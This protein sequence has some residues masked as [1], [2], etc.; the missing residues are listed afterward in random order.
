MK[1]VHTNEM[2]AKTFPMTIKLHHSDFEYVGSGQGTQHIRSIIKVRRG[3]RE[4]RG[5]REGREG[6]TIIIRARIK[7]QGVGARR[8]HRKVEISISICCKQPTHARC[9]N[10]FV[11]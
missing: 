2:E 8:H 6:D 1:T 11:L 10:V 5:K 7:S 9:C 3:G 4:E